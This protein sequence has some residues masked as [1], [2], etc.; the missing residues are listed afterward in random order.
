MGEEEQR[1][2]NE[3]HFGGRVELGFQWDVRKAVTHR[4]LLSAPEKGRG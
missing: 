4:L 3:F 1:V 2:P